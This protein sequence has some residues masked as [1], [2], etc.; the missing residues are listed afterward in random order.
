[1][2]HPF[3]AA[4]D[5]S[6]VPTRLHDDP[7]VRSADS[8][9]ESNVRTV[10]PVQDPKHASAVVDRILSA[11]AVTMSLAE[12]LSTSP[13]VRSKFRE[14]VTPK[15]V[16]ANNM[17]VP[18][19][20]PIEQSAHAAVFNANHVPAPEGLVQ[21]GRP[22]KPGVLYV[23]DPY[24][25]FLR[26][27]GPDQPHPRLEVAKPAHALRT[28]SFLVNHRENVEC[29]LDPGCQLICASE[30]AAIALGLRFDPSVVLNMISANGS[31]NP[32]L[33][34]ARNVPFQVGDITIYL[35]V[36]IIREASYDILLGRPFD[37][38]TESIVRNSRNAS[39]VVTIR[40]PNTGQ[41]LAIPT[42]PR[43]HV[44]FRTE[45]TRGSEQVQPETEDDDQGF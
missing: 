37:V 22:L 16:V 43:G 21:D 19:D 3:A 18:F 33:G 2:V 17:M 14:L 15:R 32:S 25:S 4:K 29:I 38:L 23:P 45:W 6:Y 35:Q 42:Q 20:E 1:P 7:S 8:A 12:L 26:C 28:I 36:H 44:R 39:Q 34:L 30:A 27:S 5:A 13:D 9:K 24:E 41:E 31:E 40:C 11:P 10:A